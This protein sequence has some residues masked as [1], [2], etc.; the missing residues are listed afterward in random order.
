MER[1]RLVLLMTKS[2]LIV[3]F[4]F[5]RLAVDG[6]QRILLR[7]IK[8]IQIGDLVYPAASLMSSV[9]SSAFSVTIILIW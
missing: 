3:R 9:L 6:Y 4:D 1:E 8:C 5:I 2:I 7:T